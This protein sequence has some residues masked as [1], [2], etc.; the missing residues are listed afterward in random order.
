MGE[1]E[2]Q[3]HER[4]GRYC[5]KKGA[6][7]LICAG[8]LSR[9][10]YEGALSEAEKEGRRPS[11]GIHYFPDRE[12]LLAGIGAWLEEGDTI[13]VKA[14]HSMGFEAVVELLAGKGAKAS[15]GHSASDARQLL[16]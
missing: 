11:G 4:V 16:R 3:L 15:Y 9:A 13:L 5:V 7:C 14:S 8:P 2:K 6:D 1:Q 10:M 12:A